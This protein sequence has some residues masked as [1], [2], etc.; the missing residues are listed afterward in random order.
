M[1][2]INR[3]KMLAKLAWEATSMV[4]ISDAGSHYLTKSHIGIRLLDIQDTFP[5]AYLA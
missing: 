3:I 4:N 5:A 2:T 1:F